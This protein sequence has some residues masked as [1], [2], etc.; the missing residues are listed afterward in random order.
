MLDT[1]STALGDP[2]LVRRKALE[3]VYR[4]PVVGASATTRTIGTNVFTRDWDLLV[5]L[6]TCRV[7]ALNA[8]A[9]EYDFLTE[10]TGIQSVGGA[11]PEWIAA[12]FDNA[13][14]DQIERTAYLAANASADKVLERHDVSPLWDVRESHL[15][16]RLI[17]HFD[18]VDATQLGRLEHLWQ[19]EPKGET[20]DL[21]HKSGATPPR[22]STDRTVAVGR[23]EN[24]DRLIVHYHQP[25]T[26]YVANAI[27]EGRSLRHYEEDPFRYIRQTGDRETVWETYLDEL[28]W[29]LDDVAVLLENVDAERAVISA[30][31]GE[32]LG[33]HGTYGHLIGS[34][35]PVI[36]RVPWVETTATDT[37]SYEPT[38]DPPTERDVSADDQLEALGYKF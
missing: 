32:A 18:T 21:G 8:L 5:V 38:F 4:A 28:R 10:T 36:R 17:R 35:N 13:F 14:A 2:Y 27:A 6:D 15:A 25:H 33:E 7:D 16:F 20:G 31:H 11:T 23:E 30:D 12:T 3:Y 1:V 22:Y 29:V 24:F 26:P 34:L 19:Y 37:G 9:D